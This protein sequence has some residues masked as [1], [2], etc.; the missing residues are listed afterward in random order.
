MIKVCILASSS[1]GNCALV[2]TNRTRVLVDAGLSKRE[3]FQRLAAIGED[4]KAINAILVTHEHSDHVAGLITLARSL[5]IPVYLSNLTA[6]TIAWGE[7]QPKIELFQSGST[8]TVGDIDVSSFTI[9]HD[10]IDPVGF[11]LRSQG[12]KIGIATDLGYVT[13][14]IRF[15]LRATDLLL[16]E[17]NHDLDMLKVG[18]YPWSVKQR[19]MG[20]KG[21]LS[22]DV[23]AR[24]IKSDLDTT[25]STLILGHL[26]ENNNHPEIVRLVG[27][28]ALHGRELFTRLIV[29]EPGRQ[30]EVFCY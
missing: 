12:I 4:P 19:V 15:H 2:A 22:N 28:Q 27:S 5:D 13:D 25:T 8:F 21:H 9:P 14:S 30:T 29:A 26:S 18:P 23:A 10:A 7:F 6:P 11:C 24:F 1:S 3:T 17:S 20:R 16:L